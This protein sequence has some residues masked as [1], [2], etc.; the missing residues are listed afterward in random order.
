MVRKLPKAIR[1]QL[2]QTRLKSLHAQTGFLTINKGSSSAALV[3]LRLA[4][5]EDSRRLAAGVRGSSRVQ[6][7]R[8]P[9]GPP[10]PPGRPGSGH[11][12]ASARADPHALKHAHGPAFFGLLARSR[13]TR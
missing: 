8:E 12:V 7:W 4:R 1:Q 11:G 10:K 5:V 6:Q 9:P 13:R 3:Q 2:E